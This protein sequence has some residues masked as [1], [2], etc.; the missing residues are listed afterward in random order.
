MT[1]TTPACYAVTAKL[2]GKGPAP[3]QVPARLWI[4]LG[5][6]DATASGSEDAQVRLEKG[7]SVLSLCAHHASLYELVL[8]AA[9]WRVTQDNRGGP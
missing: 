2:A 9:G 1:A 7:R 8:I 5:P 4:P 3:E 6:C